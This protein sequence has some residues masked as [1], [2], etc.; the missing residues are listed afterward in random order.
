MGWRGRKRGERGRRRKGKEIGEGERRWELKGKK[1]GERRGWCGGEKEEEELGGEG[2]GRGGGGEVSD[3][4]CSGDPLLP[5]SLPAS[6]VQYTN[7]EPL[8]RAIKK[9]SHLQ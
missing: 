1:G 3:G 2:R 9:Q 8:E 5:A 4:W 7:N 6:G